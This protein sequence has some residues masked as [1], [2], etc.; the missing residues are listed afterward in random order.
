MRVETIDVQ[1]GDRYFDQHRAILSRIADVSAEVRA[2]QGLAKRSL[3]NIV[4]MIAFIAVH[5]GLLAF[6]LLGYFATLTDSIR[7]LDWW[8]LVFHRFSACRCLVPC[9]V[10]AL[11]NYFFRGTSWAGWVAVDFVLLGLAGLLLRGPVIAREANHWLGQG[12]AT[13]MEQQVVSRTCLIR[14][15]KAAASAAPEGP[16]STQQVRRPAIPLS[17][18]HFMASAKQQSGICRSNAWFDLNIAVVDWRSPGETIEFFTG[19][20]AI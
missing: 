4:A 5:A 3:R 11:F 8:Q 14:C 12:A 17:A 13:V 10:F 2:D 19:R 1:K 20:R 7:T 15:A 9:S 16:A 6:G 18:A